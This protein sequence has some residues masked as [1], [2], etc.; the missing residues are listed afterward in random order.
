MTIYRP[1]AEAGLLLPLGMWKNLKSSLKNWKCR[2][3]VLNTECG[4]LLKVQVE[5]VFSSFARALTGTMKVMRPFISKTT[6]IPWEWPLPQTPAPHPLTSS[7]NQCIQDSH[8]Q[9][10]NIGTN[11]QQVLSVFLPALQED[12][13]WELQILCPNYSS[14][15]TRTIVLIQMS[16][17]LLLFSY[18]Q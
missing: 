3:L 5:T 13:S 12:I 8:C 7:F 14:M 10:K 11:A 6:K 18:K 9:H 16:E 17:M 2:H 15:E 4:K 1:I